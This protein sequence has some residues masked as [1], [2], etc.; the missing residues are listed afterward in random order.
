MTNTTAQSANADQIAFWNARAAETWVELQDR[1]DLFLAPFGQTT[2]DAAELR[3][4]QRVLD[5]GCGCGTT[6]LEL[7]RAVG[8]SG[9]AVGIDISSTMLEHARQ[10][11]TQTSVANARFENADA[12]THAFRDG[13]FD[14]I[15]SR[16]GNMF[17]D[18]PV[19]AFG[20]LRRALKPG[21]RLSLCCWQAVQSNPWMLVPTMAAMQHVTIE[22][23]AD[24]HAPGPFALADPERVRSILERAGFRDVRIE[25][26]TPTVTF[27][28]TIEEAVSIMM[29]L[30]P[31]ATALEKADDA[32]R[33]TVAG[34][35]ADALAP[36]MTPQ[37]VC[38]PSAAWIVTASR[39]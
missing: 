14:V 9:Q 23:P 34:A 5:L 11:A 10:R 27:G 15:Y 28:G 2:L 25:P 17:F 37:G 36:Y 20:N 4:G 29:R 21:G 8:P 39:P 38:A 1:L 13:D 19:A 32:T 18:D 16:F 24:P 35:I 12:Q 3:A 22:M 30:G 26:F 6:T 33:A 7:A 31:T